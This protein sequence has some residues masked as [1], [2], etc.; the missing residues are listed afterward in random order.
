MNPILDRM[1]MLIGLAA[2]GLL[3]AAL[4]SEYGFGLHPC[5]LCLW[6]RWPHAIAVA[7]A[8]GALAVASGLR[9]GLATAAIGLVLAA[10]TAIAVLHV[11]V[12]AGWWTG[13]TDCV[14]P[15]LGMTDPSAMVDALMDTP[16]VRC[17]EVVFRFLG[18]SMAGWNALLSAGLAAV[19]G[20]AAWRM[21]AG[22]RETARRS[23]EETMA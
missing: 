17:D 11:G 1:P 16:L 3:G 14:G 15:P 13:P 18:L 5:Q 19:A 21:I 7:L 2:A 9:R 12:E 4:V 6:Q 8:L 22:E 10:G 23:Q 20:V